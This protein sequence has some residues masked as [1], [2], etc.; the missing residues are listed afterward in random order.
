MFKYLI[1]WYWWVCFQDDDFPSAPA[2]V[3]PWI[4]YPDTSVYMVVLSRHAVVWFI[5]LSSFCPSFWQGRV[6]NILCMWKGGCT[7]CRK[8]NIGFL[9][10]LLCKHLIS[11]Q[12]L[13]AQSTQ[14]MYS[15]LPW[16]ATLLWWDQPLPSWAWPSSVSSRTL[17]VSLADGPQLAQVG[18]GLRG[19]SWAGMEACSREEAEWGF[20]FLQHW[21]GSQWG[22]KD[23]EDG[24]QSRGEGREWLKR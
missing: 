15:A 9:G 17:H 13:G 19:W 5:L 1:L 2:L 24:P 21:Q 22:H 23:T 8:I 20:W 11:S 4:L 16:T 3:T 14:Q 10:H 6:M 18:E 12:V 7:L